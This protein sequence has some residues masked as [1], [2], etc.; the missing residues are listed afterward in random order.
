MRKIIKTFEK[1]IQRTVLASLT[2]VSLLVGAEALS[3][4]NSPRINNQAQLEEKLREN[5]EKL[6]D[7][8]NNSLKIHIRKPKKD[9]PS[10]GSR[11]I[12]EREYEIVLSNANESVLKHELYHIADGHTDSRYRLLLYL[13]WQE[14]QAA[15][16]Q[17]TGLKP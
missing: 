10:A 5:G 3:E 17:I 4:I 12:G 15:I 16:Y 2:Y 1:A 7:K 14:P 13:F 8:I 11:K 6:R 9:E